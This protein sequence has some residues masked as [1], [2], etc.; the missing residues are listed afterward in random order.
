MARFPDIREIEILTPIEWIDAMPWRRVHHM[1][2]N[3]VM[4]DSPA[5]LTAA[6]T[7]PVRHEMRADFADFPPYEGGVFHFPFATEAV[8]PP[9]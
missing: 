7:S 6:L 2:R 8:R 4:F 5:A 3:R 1:Q 9:Q